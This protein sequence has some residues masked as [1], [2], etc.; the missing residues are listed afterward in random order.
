MPDDLEGF[1][2]RAPPPAGWRVEYAPRVG[3]TNDLAR[4]AALAGAPDRTVFVADFQT[5]GRGRQ[6]RA[7]LAPPGFGLLFSTLFRPASGDSV[8]LE[9]TMR[10]ALALAEAAEALGLRPA[11]KWPNDL[12]LGDR[13]VA[14]IL[15]ESFASGQGR[16]VVVGCGVNVGA[17]PAD[18]PPTATTLSAVAGRRLH[19]GRLLLAILRRLDGW[20]S[21]PPADVRRAWRARLW[22]RD[23][24]VRALEGGE[25]L[26]GTIA[27]VAD[28]GTLLLRL[29]DGT[30]RRL[31]SGELLP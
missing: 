8:P 15:A 7:W 28:D 6:G 18:L 9:Y 12:L 29:V 20:L 23:Q 27:D 1:V 16:A 26:V 17:P 5:A 2:R 14:G 3:S 30:L 21:S 25:P 11:I 31:V 10:A 4:A 13:K 19:R 22:G 24:V